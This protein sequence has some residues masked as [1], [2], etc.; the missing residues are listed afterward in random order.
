MVLILIYLTFN[1]PI[2]VWICADQFRNIPKELDKA[3][4][5]EG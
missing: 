1:I 3:A 2:V 4:T 5:L